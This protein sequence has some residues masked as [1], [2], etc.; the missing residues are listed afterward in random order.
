MNLM[1]QVVRNQARLDKRLR[2]TERPRKRINSSGWFQAGET[3]TYA[4]A[5]TFTITDDADNSDLDDFTNVYQAGDF[6][7]FKQGAGYL[8]A[9]I[10]AVAYAD[11]TTTVTISGDA[12]ADATITDNYYSKALSPQGADIGDFDAD[13]FGSG[14]A[15]DGY[16]LTADGSDGAAWEAAGLT[17]T[18]GYYTSTSWDGDAKNGASGTIDLS[19]VFGVPEGVTA[20]AVA[21]SISD[22]S[23][24]VLMR[25]S[26]ESGAG[27]GFD[28]RTQRGGTIDDA[29]IVTCDSNGDIYFY[30]S[31][32]FDHVS[33]TII[34][35]WS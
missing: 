25:L 5:T 2:H 4:S 31:G 6:I 20:V 23:A 1:E 29:G 26:S 28:S 27:D 21:I 35:Y 33:I 3:W 24:G 22:E 30:Q 32:E 34:G 15:T 17:F 12:I 9:C 8:H 7:R 11:P 18:P 14:A 10:T 16:V 19:A 13:Q